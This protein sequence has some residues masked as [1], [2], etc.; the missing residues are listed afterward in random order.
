MPEY[1]IIRGMGGN[2]KIPYGIADFKTI[3]EEGLCS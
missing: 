3:R 1:G 2:L